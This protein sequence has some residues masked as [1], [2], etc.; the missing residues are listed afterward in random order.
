M[1]HF[2]KKDKEKEEKDKK[3]TK[4]RKEKKDSKRIKENPLTRDELNRLDEVRNSHFGDLKPGAE[5]NL[6]GSDAGATVSPTDGRPSS[7]TFP[8]DSSE[9]NLSSPAKSPENGSFKSTTN[10]PSLKVQGRLLSPTKSSTRPPVPSAKIPVL[11]SNSNNKGILKSRSL[12]LNKSVV[13]ESLAANTKANENS[14]DSKQGRF[15]TSKSNRSASRSSNLSVDEIDRAH[16]NKDASEL[17]VD[18]FGVGFGVGINSVKLKQLDLPL[19]PLSAAKHPNPRTLTIPRL[20]AGDFGFSLRRAAII[21]KH[22]DQNEQNKKTIIFAEPGSLG[23]TNNTGLLPG[24]RL[25]KVNDISVENK[26]RDEIIT[27]IKSSGDFVKLFVQLIP[28]LV[29]LTSRSSAI[30]GQR[31]ELDESYV[32]GGTL[33]RSGS[34]RFKKSAKSEDQLTR[35]KKWLDEE[36]VWILHKEGYSAA[37]KVQSNS[38]VSEGKVLVQIESN[39]QTMEAE[40]EEVETANPPHYDKIE[41]LSQLRYLNESSVLHVLR[42]RYSS[43]L[44]HTYSGTTMLIINPAHP[45]PIYSEKVMQLFKGCR[46]EDMPPHIYAVAQSA[47]RKLLTSRKDQSIVFM[48][49]SGSGK[50][51]NFRHILQY[52]VQISGSINKFLTTEKINAVATLLEAFGNS[53]TVMNSNS[54]RF[55]QLFSVDYDQTGQI[56]S[57]SI[58]AFLLER[59]RV[60]RRPVKEPTFHVLYQMIAGVDG[61]LRKELMLENLT[62]FNIFMTPLQRIEDKQKATLAWACIRNAMDI[63]GISNEEV[64]ALTSVLAAIYHLGSAGAVTGSGSSGA[65]FSKPQNAQKAATLLGTTVEELSRNVFQSGSSSIRN[66]SPTDKVEVTNEDAVDALEATVAGL[67]TE[68]FNALISLMNRCLTSGNR[69]M[70]SILLFDCPGLQNPAT[71]GRVSGASF[72]ELCQNY[73]QDRLQLLFHENT[74]VTQQDKYAQE[75]VVCDLGDLSSFIT[76]PAA[77]VSILDKQSHQ[78][79]ALAKTSISDLRELNTSDQKGLLWILDEESLCLNSTNRS[80]L[81]RIKNV[82]SADKDKNSFVKVDG[83]SLIINHLQGTNPVRYNTTGWLRACRE[84]SATRNSASLLQDSDNDLISKLFVYSRGSGGSGNLS[85]MSLEAGSSASLRR[86]SSIRRCVGS[87]GGGL[88]RRSVPLQVKFQMDAIIETLRR[89]SLH[90]IQCILP[91]Q[92]SAASE[93]KSSLN[94]SP[95]FSSRASDESNE[96]P[97]LD[98]PLL[99]SQLRG[100]QVL[101]ALRMH[102]LGYPEQMMFTE[103]KRRFALLVPGEERS[104]TSSPDLDERKAADMM[105]E[106]LDIERSSYRLGIS[107]IFFRVGVLTQLEDQRDDKLKD[108]IIK[109]QAYCRGCLGRKKIKELRV[110]DL[111][112]RCIQRNIRKFNAIKSWDW[113][114]LYVK[115]LPVLD[116]HKTEQDLK[117]KDEELETLRTK[118]EKAEKERNQFKHERDRLEARMS[119]LTADLVE[120]HATTV[121]AG[122]VL[123]AQSSERMRLEREVQDLQVDASSSSSNTDSDGEPDP[124]PRTPLHDPVSRLAGGYKRHHIEL[125][126]GSAIAEKPQKRCRMCYRA[127]IRKDTRYHCK[128]CDSKLSKSQ[129]LTEDLE[130]ELM[131]TRMFQVS[132]INGDISDDDSGMNIYKEKYE[133]SVREFEFLKK[134]IHQQHEEEL[135]QGLG[136]RKAVDKKLNQALTDL[137]EE[138]HATMQWKKK[139]QKLNSDMRDL[140]MLL[141]NESSRNM[142]L[143]KK[144]RKFDSELNHVQEELKH[145]KMIKEKICREKE[146]IQS[147][148]YS[149][150]QEL[151]IAFKG[152]SESLQQTSFYEKILSLVKALARQL[153]IKVDSELQSEKLNLLN[154]EIDELTFGNKGGDEIFQLKKV[155]HELERK[156]QDQEE[157]LDD[158]AGQVQMLEQAKLR[159]EMNIEKLRQEH[160]KEVSARDEEIEEARAIASKKL[161][162]LEMQLET[163]HEE[164]QKLNREKHEF[165]RRILDLQDR[166]P[167]IDPEIERRLRRDLKRTKALLRDSQ[168]MLDHNHENAANKSAIRQ[169]KNQLEDVEFAKTAA[170]KSKLGV[171]MELEDVKLQLEGISKAKAEAVQKASSLGREKA[172]LQSQLEESEEEVAEVMKKYKTAVFQLSVDQATTNEQSCM[173]SDLEAEKQCLKSLLADLTSKVEILEGETTDIHT[174]KR[175]E[176]KI[177]ELESKLDLESTHKS[178][179]ETQHVRLKEQCEKYQQE[180]SDLRSKEQQALDSCKKLTRQMRDSKEDYSDLQ[181]KESEAY[182]KISML[183]QTL[184]TAETEHNA[185]KS[186]LKLAFRRI[187]DLQAA[188]EGE[189]GSDYSD[190]SENDSDSEYSEHDEINT[191]LGRRE[192]SA[193]YR[194]VSTS[195]SE[196]LS[197]SMRHSSSAEFHSLS[198]GGSRVGL[199]DEAETLSITG[200]KSGAQH[201]EEFV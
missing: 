83:D 86:M 97:S 105:I 163:E 100:F 155:K 101:D 48:G 5:L 71:C 102:K 194:T 182:R 19:P 191:F 22:G 4:E 176:M 164:R 151:Q 123:D 107:K 49:R 57:A 180:S 201:H 52:L 99:R 108:L 148:K 122:E 188:I 162:S 118:M 137:E 92:N 160:R 8:S 34:K 45:L 54:T 199:S 26:N 15:L 51:S 77:I 3:K 171:E 161:K 21:D 13:N 125:F 50:T 60:A 27:L 110:Q 193:M 80:F 31:I 190:L 17:L 133:R 18:G 68:V 179:L 115:L 61:A 58:Q 129:K 76:N 113:W 29:E 109:L 16:S 63:L 39:G 81:D 187:E 196:G 53:R 23:R 30:D 64:K 42:Q 170:I 154:K 186:D 132:E 75:N 90:F 140:K 189:M 166:P 142:M 130:M 7:L 177:R 38:S 167:E 47:Y 134:R 25:L 43:N 169:L 82:L 120:E 159:L 35:E 95:I 44:I 119:D 198:P 66:Q 10:I 85:L 94:A 41:E 78:S 20:P 185:T 178:H 91:H 103:F 152:V 32:R 1:F 175:L 128:E 93:L 168:L 153:S 135:E 11:K 184:E 173:I 158:L 136:Q 74:F 147:E 72:Q 56:A 2:R 65:Q 40:E 181:Q 150:E 157:E 145:E 12:S 174:V 112:I 106:H 165:E 138:H 55:T 79:L 156:S 84:H 114:R 6:G 28:E 9:S 104:S 183:E 141:E 124:A 126:P 111:A 87:G 146:I 37:K 131:E 195:S 14:S 69:S 197:S 24:D 200:S 89:T 67:Y 127:E 73:A 143:E 36:K 96:F 70:S 88:K 172:E 62:D 192:S 59:N 98:I 149:L 33:S 144:Q 139:W 117:N 121:Q 116:V 46:Q